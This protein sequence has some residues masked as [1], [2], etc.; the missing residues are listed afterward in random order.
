[1]LL[2]P[3]LEA[4]KSIYQLFYHKDINITHY[5]KP[6]LPSY[7]FAESY[8]QKIFP[9]EWKYVMVGDNLDTDIAGAYNA[10]W[11]S[12]YTKTKPTL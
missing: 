12:I 8:T 6:E 4:L 5:G 1:M 3:F 9:G 7:K 10:K 2:K 11:D